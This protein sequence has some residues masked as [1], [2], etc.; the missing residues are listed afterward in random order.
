[1]TVI[2]FIIMI[3]FGFVFFFS[4]IGRTAV[5]MLLSAC[6]CFG[7]ILIAVGADNNAGI[8]IFGWSLVA[9]AVIGFIIG[10]K[11]DEKIEKANAEIERI[12]KERAEEIEREEKIKGIAIVIYKKCREK[13]IGIKNEEDLNSLLIITKMYNVNDI[14][15][16]KELYL[17]GKRLVSEEE[18]EELERKIAKLRNSDTERF[19]K[20]KETALLYGKSKYT[21]FIEAELVQAQIGMK[22]AEYLKKV[23]SSNSNYTAQKQDWAIA[24][25]LASGLAGGA[26]GVSAALDAQ[27]RNANEEYRASQIREQG[28]QQ[29][30][31]AISY[32]VHFEGEAKKYAEMLDK[33]NSK[34]I[35]T[36]NINEKFEMLE[37][38]KLECRVRK[39]KNIEITGICKIKKQP[40]LLGGEAILDGAVK[41]NVYNSQDKFVGYGYY[42]PSKFEEKS[43]KNFKYLGFPVYAYEFSSICIVNGYA[44]ENDTYYCKI[45]PVHL[46]LIEI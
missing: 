17:L 21:G 39:S 45:E 4:I 10:F 31:S 24:G 15:E 18:K 1:M 14:E 20:E 16:A 27:Q 42:S 32:G 44:D 13:S 40:K 30:S 29:V 34:I 28:R 25:G 9:V 6:G 8:V 22:G 5:G 37:F 12:E 46:W 11:H 7:G 26:A 36:E 35:D 33:I 38:T 43:L 2:A 19:N 23:G 41:I 3:V